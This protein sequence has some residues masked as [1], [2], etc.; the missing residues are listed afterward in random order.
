MRTTLTIED[1]VAVKLE[2]LRRS[3]D[4]SLKAVINEALR[5][6][7]REMSS[8]PRVRRP[9]TAAAF[10]MGSPLISIDNVAEALASVEGE[11]FK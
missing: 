9:V 5:L 3:R 6:G 4:A 8:P 10:H 1:D 11:S 7:I 2:V